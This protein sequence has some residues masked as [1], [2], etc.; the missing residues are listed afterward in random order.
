[1]TLAIRGRGDSHNIEYRTDATANAVLTPNGGRGGIDVGAIHYASAVRRLTPRECERLQGFPD[2]YTRIRW[3]G[4]RA[5]G[6]DET[7]ES[8]RAQG[9]DV[10]QTKKGKWRVNDVDG[11]RYKALGNSFAVPVVRW[12]GRR[13]AMVE[14]AHHG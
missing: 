5:M 3:N 12:I 6:A 2:D 13:I 10:R 4:W 11:P 1:M 7:P 14:A 8:C 9:L